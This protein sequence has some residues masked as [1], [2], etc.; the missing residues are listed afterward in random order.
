MLG[1]TDTV[2]S[3]HQVRTS[4]GNDARRV[5]FVKNLCGHLGS[6]TCLALSRAF[7]VL[8]SGSE[9]RTCIVWDIN[10]LRYVRQLPRSTGHDAPIASIAINDSTG[11]IITCAGTYVNVW[12]I[13]GDLL[14]SK[15]TSQAVSETITACTVSKGAAWIDSHNVVATGQRNGAQTT[16]QLK[17]PLYK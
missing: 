4:A 3:V 14:I 8:V 15:R 11:E 5:R 7:S 1:G 9:D 17:A 10:R 6:I 2:V 16:L 13:N 12:S